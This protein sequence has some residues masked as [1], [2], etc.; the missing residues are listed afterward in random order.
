M[1]FTD[2]ENNDTNF[3][4]VKISLI[5]DT[6]ALS[7]I[8]ALKS[9]EFPGHK[10]QKMHIRFIITEKKINFEKP[11][12]DEEISHMYVYNKMIKTD[13]EKT[14]NSEGLVFT[15]KEII[16]KQRAVV[17]YLIKK[18]GMNILTGKSIMNV[19]LPINIF[20]IRSHLEVYAYQNSYSSFI[21]KA[22]KTEDKLEKLK[23]VTIY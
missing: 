21:E 7:A 10:E 6:F 2:A 9:N 12:P 3:Q 15:N 18:V 8:E 19:S 5:A 16:D 22:A 23:L 17:G 4:N 14:L 20:D 13:F 11:L 1:T